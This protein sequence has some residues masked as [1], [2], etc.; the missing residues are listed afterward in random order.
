MKKYIYILISF[1]IFTFTA[2]AQNNISLSI[3]K[4]TEKGETFVQ[5]SLKNSNPKEIKI[6][7]FAQWGGTEYLVSPISY[8]AFIGNPA[9][10]STKK[11]TGKIIMTDIFDDR[12]SERTPLY[13]TLKA[14]ATH[15]VKYKLFGEDFVGFRSFPVSCKNQI[16][17]LQVKA[18]IQSIYDL[19]S[20]Y[21][22]VI[23]S[24]IITL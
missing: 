12:S 23:F 3:A 14:G 8:Y 19:K 9:S 6:I 4:I 2:K 20:S 18:S 22:E 17:T 21:N 10:L 1:L 5:I 16:K 7:S 24:N 13:I 11:E 15:V